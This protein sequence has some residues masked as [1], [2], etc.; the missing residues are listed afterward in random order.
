VNGD[1]ILLG[2][3]LVITDAQVA[4]LAERTAIAVRS[5]LQRHSR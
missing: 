5:V 3:P 2:P 4:E 1:L